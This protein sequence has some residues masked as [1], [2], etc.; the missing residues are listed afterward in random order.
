MFIVVLTIPPALLSI[1]GVHR[2]RSLRGGV[3]GDGCERDL[4]HPMVGDS[5]RFGEVDSIRHRLVYATEADGNGDWPKSSYRSRSRSESR[6]WPW[7]TGNSP[8]GGSKGLF[9]GKSGLG[10]D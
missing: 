2:F 6:K 9:G 10:G 4:L 1:L 3:H 7:P 8:R 5:G